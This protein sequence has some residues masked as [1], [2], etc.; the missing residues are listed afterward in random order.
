MPF[1]HGVF[2]CLLLSLVELMLSLSEHTNVDS[3][4][5]LLA[6]NE[7]L[8]ES[9]RVMFK[10]MKSPTHCLHVLLPPNTKLDYNL[11]NNESCFTP[12]YLQYI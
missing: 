10:K 12:V 8:V 5:E 6:V 11:R 9:G 2:L 7:L 1:R 4:I 3:L